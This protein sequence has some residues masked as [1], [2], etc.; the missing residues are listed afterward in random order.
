MCVAYQLVTKDWEVKRPDHE[1]D[2]LYFDRA[3]THKKIRLLLLAIYRML[4]EKNE[5]HVGTKPANNL[6]DDKLLNS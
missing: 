1:C 6:A 4:L 2:F 3:N 5:Q